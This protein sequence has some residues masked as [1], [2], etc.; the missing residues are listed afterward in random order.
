MYNYLKFEV[1]LKVNWFIVFKIIVFL[2]DSVFGKKRKK[3]YVFWIVEEKEV[4]F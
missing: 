2:V 4:V 3:G 1:L